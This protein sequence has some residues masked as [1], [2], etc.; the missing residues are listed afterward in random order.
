MSG[1]SSAELEGTI[2][3][4]ASRNAL[5]HKLKQT[6]EAGMPSGNI[7]GGAAVEY[8]GYTLPALG[9]ALFFSILGLIYLK[10]GK[11]DTDIPMMV[12]GV[13][14]MVYTYFVSDTIAILLVG[15]LLASLPSILKRI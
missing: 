9:L 11:S 7:Q 10:I 1:L 3:Y 14:L 6:I 15:I 8:F 12:S 5:F 4:M 13:L 2:D